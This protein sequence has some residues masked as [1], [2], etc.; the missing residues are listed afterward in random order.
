MSAATNVASHEQRVAELISRDIPLDAAH[1]IASTESANEAQ[2]KIDLADINHLRS[3]HETGRTARANV[4]KKDSYYGSSSKNSAIRAFSQAAMFQSIGLGSILG[5]AG[6]IFNGL[7]ADDVLSHGKTAASTSQLAEDT[8]ARKDFAQ[9]LLA[10]QIEDMPQAEQ[11]A[12]IEQ[13]EQQIKLA[14]EVEILAND[15]ASHNPDVDSCSRDQARAIVANI[16]QQGQSCNV[17]HETQIEFLN[18]EGIAAETGAQGGTNIVTTHAF[19]MSVSPTHTQEMTPE[20]MT[21]PAADA[22]LSSHF[23]FGLSCSAPADIMPA[24]TQYSP[25]PAEPSA[26][27]MLINQRNLAQLTPTLALN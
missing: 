2:H 26:I 7:S 11:T 4:E 17:T 23:S 9:E 15:T 12:I 18:K 6:S 14:V 24:E 21:A 5:Q 1:L 3:G 20:N 13:V 22:S 27:D 10:D 16:A 19:N 25:V 8:S